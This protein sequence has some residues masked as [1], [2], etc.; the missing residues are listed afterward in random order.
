MA[1]YTVMTKFKMLKTSNFWEPKPKIPSKKAEQM[2]LW[3][4]LRNMDDPEPPQCPNFLGDDVPP[5][6]SNEESDDGRGPPMIA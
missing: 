5:L 2:A 3:E 6:S 1:D 4:E